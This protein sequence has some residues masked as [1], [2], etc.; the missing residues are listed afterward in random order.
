MHLTSYK[1][2]NIYVECI[3][4]VV[5]KIYWAKQ[6]TTK[7]NLIYLNLKYYILI[8]ELHIEEYF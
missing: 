1:Q 7:K 8:V 4:I 6:A 3:F 2:K 5:T